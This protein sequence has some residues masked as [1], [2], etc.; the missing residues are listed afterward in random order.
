MHLL[1]VELGVL[2]PAWTRWHSINNARLM[3]EAVSDVDVVT[4]F[5]WQIDAAV[6]LESEEELLPKQSFRLI[7]FQVF[8]GVARASMVTRIVTALYLSSLSVLLQ[9]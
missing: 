6:D 9:C 4:E 7:N 2:G 1:V 5:T 8:G 3:L